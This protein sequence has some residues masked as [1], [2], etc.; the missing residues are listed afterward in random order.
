MRD[1]LTWMDC[2]GLETQP[3]GKVGFK[4][5]LNLKNL[6]AIGMMAEFANTGQEDSM[7]LFSTF[8]SVG[9]ALSQIVVEWNWIGENNK[10]LAQPMNNPDVFEEL[11]LQELTWLIS[12]IQGLV[13]GP[14]R[15]GDLIAPGSL[16][17]TTNGVEQCQKT[18]LN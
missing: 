9:T 3:E 8:S 7:D 5:H 11:T 12:K 17:R 16:D 15:R 6:R 13:L 10:P 18:L 2:E 4:T 14:M 1:K